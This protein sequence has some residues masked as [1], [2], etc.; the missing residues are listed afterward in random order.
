[1]ATRP[2]HSTP[3]KPTPRGYTQYSSK[4]APLVEVRKKQLRE[5]MHGYF[6]GPM[7]P[8]EFMRSFMPVNSQNPLSPPDGIDFRRV[9]DQANE[10]SMY[11]PFVRFCVVL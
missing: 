7:D 9:Y 2:F 5:N 3:P 1:M 6:L 4:P 11:T 10:R 8:S